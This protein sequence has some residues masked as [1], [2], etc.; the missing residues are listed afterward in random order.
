ME[1]FFGHLKS[2]V[3]DLRTFRTDE[4]VI[5]AIDRYMHFYN[6]ERFQKIR[7]PQSCRISNHQGSLADERM[8]WTP[9]SAYQPLKLNEG[10]V[11]KCFP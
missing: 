7:L 10:E 6:H 9:S 2:E 5:L 8:I 4:E 3:M 11:V 1:N